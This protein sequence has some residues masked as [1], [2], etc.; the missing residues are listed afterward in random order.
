MIQKLHEIKQ[1][2]SIC[3]SRADEV[4][5]TMKPLP[6]VI[7][8]QIGVILSEK[9]I[10]K[11]FEAGIELVMD[12]CPAEELPRLGIYPAPPKRTRRKSDRKRPRQ[13]EQ[14]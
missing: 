5:A 3:N 13:D 2:L 11:V 9:V 12:K 7:W 6:K 10:E 4:L 1:Y 8:C 14:V